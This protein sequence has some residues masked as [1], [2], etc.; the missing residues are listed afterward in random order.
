MPKKPQARATNRMGVI[1]RLLIDESNEHGSVIFIMIVDKKL[2]C[3][4]VQTPFVF[5]ANPNIIIKI[6]PPALIK[7][8]IIQFNSFIGFI[9][10]FTTK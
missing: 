10:A 4:R 9:I 7:I 3:S 5:S 6:K 8:S 1:S 2:P